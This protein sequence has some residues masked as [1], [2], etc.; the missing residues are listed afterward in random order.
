MAGQNTKNQAH[1][2][3]VQ[4]RCGIDEAG[5]G[6]LAGPVVASAVILP[7]D[8]L[9]SSLGDSKTLSPGR[10][11]E[12]ETRIHT[13][14]ALIGYGWVWPSEIDRINI[15]QAS[16][17]AMGRAWADLCANTLGE[18][19]NPRF[20]DRPEIS[21]EIVVDGIHCPTG[22]V[23]LPDRSIVVTAIA[24]ADRS[25]PEVMAASILAKTAR[26]RWMIEYAERDGRYGFERHK[27]YPTGAHKAALL[28]HGPCP[29]HRRSFRG[30]PDGPVTP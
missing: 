8:F 1:H 12:E 25:V 3:I 19:E 14:G 6:P 5:R 7:R 29:I 17:L 24:G 13:S 27:G 4:G 18:P 16:L 22:L 9:V 28:L 2:P 21:G 15:L 10:R 23:T 26:D 20:G 11:N 30:V